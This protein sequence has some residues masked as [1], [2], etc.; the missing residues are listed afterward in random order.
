ML[1]D[2]VVGGVEEAGDED[3]A[4]AGDEACCAGLRG[5][6]CDLL[7][8][9]HQAGGDGCDAE[10]LRDGKRFLQE[11]RGEDSREDGCAGEDDLVQAGACDGEPSE[12]REKA[13]ELVER[14]QEEFSPLGVE[15]A[16][17]KGEGGRRGGLM[18][19]GLVRVDGGVH[20]V[21]LLTA[22]DADAQGVE[23]AED[24]AAEEVDQ[25]DAQVIREGQEEGGAVAAARVQH[26]L[27]AYR[28]H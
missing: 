5:G 1:C 18:L 12:P 20:A 22:G 8:G 16:C 14:E 24:A 21:G 7:C 6:V 13:R 28:L 2:D 27:D 25:D 9:D 19:R 26:A 10:P 4:H 15:E 23:E 11:K 3:E 17:G